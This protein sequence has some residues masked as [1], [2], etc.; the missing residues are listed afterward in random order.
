MCVITLG[1][2]WTWW[3][4]YVVIKLSIIFRILAKMNHQENLSKNPTLPTLF[5]IFTR[6]KILQLQSQKKNQVQIF[7]YLPLVLTCTRLWRL[8]RMF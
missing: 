8:K 6:A 3:Y 1:Q 2:F 5:N 7:A 4:M